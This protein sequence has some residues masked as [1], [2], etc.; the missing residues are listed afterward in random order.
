MDNYSIKN[1][2]LS[3]LI[4][5]YKVDRYRVFSIQYSTID[6]NCS[7]IRRLISLH[8]KLMDSAAPLPI[9]DHQLNEPKRIS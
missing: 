5:I 1:E 2:L 9:G 7:T 8:L 3:K 6:R 4:N